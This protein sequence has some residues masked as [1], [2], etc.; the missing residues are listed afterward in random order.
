MS[1]FPLEFEK[2]TS[3]TS[4]VV[5]WTVRAKQFIR[6]T[7]SDF[8]FQYGLVARVGSEAKLQ[9]GTDVWTQHYSGILT[10]HGSVLPCVANCCQRTHAETAGGSGVLYTTQIPSLVTAFLKTRF[11][12][13]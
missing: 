4:F 11:L 1:Q 13:D 2:Y 5:K 12:P 3:E 7:E 6:Q 9:K 10:A 8:K